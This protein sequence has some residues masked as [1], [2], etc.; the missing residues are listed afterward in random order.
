[1][2]KHKA[3]DQRVDQEESWRDE[4]IKEALRERNLTFIE[5]SRKCQDRVEWRK[6]IAGTQ[7]HTPKG[8][9]GD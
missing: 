6:I 9:N 5:G 4:E 1:M 7:A 8:R 2:L 3:K